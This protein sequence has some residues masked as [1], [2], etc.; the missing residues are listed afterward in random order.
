MAEEGVQPE[1][2]GSQVNAPP[3]AGCM[4][5]V[6]R[7]AVWTNRRTRCCLSADSLWL[8]HCSHSGTSAADKTALLQAP[9]Q[10]RRVELLE[11]G[12]RYAADLGA[13]QKTGFFC[14]QRDS[15]QLVRSLAKGLRML[16]LCR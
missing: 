3:Q 8:K 2:A 13:G 9:Q 7:C 11:N 14:D 1:A 10:A 16:D 12:V 4:L 5:H 15:R 6:Q